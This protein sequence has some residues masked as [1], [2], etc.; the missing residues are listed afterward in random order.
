MTVW[1]GLRG[2][3]LPRRA[4]RLRAVEAVV[5]RHA[6]EVLRSRRTA[7]ES[8]AAEPSPSSQKWWLRA[9]RYLENVATAFAV[10]SSVE[11]EKTIYCEEREEESVANPLFLFLWI[12]A[13]LWKSFFYP[14]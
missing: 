11:I 5:G 7:R 13:L 14:V 12:S 2:F 6:A 1:V 9:A 10:Y 4:V 8:S 3:L